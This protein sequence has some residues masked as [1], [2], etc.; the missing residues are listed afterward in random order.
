MITNP[1]AIYSHRLA[2]KPDGVCTLRLTHATA[3]AKLA[4]AVSATALLASGCSRDGAD[5]SA[6][7]QGSELQAGHDFDAT[8]ETG[9]NKTL[10][11]ITGGYGAIVDSGATVVAGTTAVV[12]GSRSD[13]LVGIDSGSGDHKWTWKYPDDRPNSVDVCDA[14]VDS[15]GIFCLVDGDVIGIDIETG[16]QLWALTEEDRVSAAGGELSP[17]P[18]LFDVTSDAVVI[19]AYGDHNNVERISTATGDIEWSSTVAENDDSCGSDWST[20]AGGRSRHAVVGDGDFVVAWGQLFDG[21]DGTNLG[22]EG[23]TYAAVAADRYLECTGDSRTALFDNSGTE[24]TSTDG[25]ADRVSLGLTTSDAL[26][27]VGDQWFKAEDGSE[28]AEDPCN[29][30]KFYSQIIVGDACLMWGADDLVRSNAAA[31]SV[32]LTTGT[33]DVVGFDSRSVILKSEGGYMWAPPLFE[34]ETASVWPSEVEVEYFT[35]GRAGSYDA[36]MTPSGILLV[37][38]G[39]VA[40]IN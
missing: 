4:I 22:A 18:N 3:L 33:P 26:Y 39:R 17:D 9:W 29:S 24:I 20:H 34:E 37:S 2:T 12:F 13:G 1:C 10:Q 28:V 30:A 31:S 15:G 27:R 21:T 5:G 38:G 25:S 7:Q 40:L 23:T 35:D 6:A 19:G 16:S 14:N 36:V 32:K 8:P 11:E